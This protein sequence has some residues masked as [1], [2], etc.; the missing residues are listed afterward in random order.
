[1]Y[2]KICTAQ[3]MCTAQS[4]SLQKQQMALTELYNTKKIIDFASNQ[5]K[6]AK[7][8]VLQMVEKK[9]IKHY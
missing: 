5:A 6:Q 8:R 7:L 2:N 1:M 4:H 3:N 9:V